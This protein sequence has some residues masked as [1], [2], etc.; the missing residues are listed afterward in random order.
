MHEHGASH[1]PGTT[2]TTV[3]GRGGGD[4]AR[5]SPTLSEIANSP[6]EEV[7]HRPHARLA[8][9][10]GLIIEPEQLQIV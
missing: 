8:I 5:H 9:C 7:R 4:R 10:D 2:V 3:L 1:E 6:R